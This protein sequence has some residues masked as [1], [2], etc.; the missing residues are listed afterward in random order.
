MSRRGLPATV[1]IRSL[2]AI[3]FLKHPSLSPLPCTPSPS[4][5]TQSMEDSVLGRAPAQLPAPPTAPHRYIS[6]DLGNTQNKRQLFSYADSFT[7]TVCSGW[8]TR[9]SGL[10]K[11]ATSLNHLRGFVVLP[12]KGLCL[13]ECPAVTWIS[14]A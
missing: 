11:M 1:V 10:C 12:I 13:F 2:G 7:I 3:S 5:H 8:H 14:N 4:P 6:L 9:K